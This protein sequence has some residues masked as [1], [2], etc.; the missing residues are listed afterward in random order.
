RARKKRVMV[1]QS[2]LRLRDATRLESRSRKRLR[3]G[4]LPARRRGARADLRRLG[5]EALF[6]ALEVLRLGLRPAAVGQPQI[7]LGF[8]GAGEAFAQRPQAERPADAAGVVGQCLLERL[9]S[10]LS[11]AA[12]QRPGP[13]RLHQY[14]AVAP[15]AA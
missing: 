5:G 14:R 3:A 12:L 8:L 15:R 2:R 6:Q 7:A 1:I 4:S 13:P 11:I 9:F 10:L